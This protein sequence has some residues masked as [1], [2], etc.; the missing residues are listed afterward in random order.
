MV[1]IEYI[2]GIVR[3]NTTYLNSVFKILNNHALHIQARL[4][5]LLN[6]SNPI[7]SIG[8]KN[9]YRFKQIGSRKKCPKC[10]SEN[11]E[12]IGHDYDSPEAEELGYYEYECKDCCHV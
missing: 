1:F 9:V 6:S 12:M 8:N 7:F 10:S 3:Y 2:N 11:V 4:H 5:D